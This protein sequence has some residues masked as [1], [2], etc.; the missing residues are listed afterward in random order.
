MAFFQSFALKN[1]LPF[2]LNASASIGT[3]GG[4]LVG[5]LAGGGLVGVLCGG[6]RGAASCLFSAAP[7]TFA[8]PPLG[9]G[10]APGTLLPFS[11]L[12]GVGEVANSLSTS[13]GCGCCSLATDMADDSRRSSSGG[14]FSGCE[15]GSYL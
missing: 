6:G 8:L 10:K 9:W 11:G 13:D 12:D 14:R 1:L 3:T 15:F 4:G 5:F 7:F 2:A